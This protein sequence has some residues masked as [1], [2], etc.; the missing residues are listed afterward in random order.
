MLARRQLLLAPATLAACPALAQPASG[1]VIGPDSVPELGGVTLTRLVGG[2]ANPWALAVLPDGDMLVTERPGRL[3]RISRGR[4]DP[5]PVEGVPAVAAFGQGGLLDIALAPDFARDRTL[6]LSFAEGNSAANRT[7]VLRARL[8]GARLADLAVI[9]RAVPD[10]PGGA[11]FGSR[12]LFLPDGTLLVSVGDGGNPNI[13]IDGMPPREQ[14]QRPASALGKLH[15]LNPD[16]SIPADNPFRAAE[17][18]LA[19]LYS[20]GHRNIQGLAWDATR[21]A[22]WASEHGSSGG[23]EL[24]VILRG[25]NFGW[26]RATHSVEYGS[27]APISP[28]RSLPGMEDPKLV[29]LRGIAPSGLAVHSGRGAAAFRGDVFAGGLQSADV[30]RIQAGADGRITGQQ[31]IPVGVRVRDVREGPDGAL[32][33]LTDSQDGT[34]FRVALA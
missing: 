30:R 33:V 34:L 23:D 5:A 31:R 2:L 27:G 16:G 22:V 32:L 3:R 19:S 7:A 18:A 6:F 28:D 1:P 20:I 8:D 11:H 25:R 4:L 26:P 17:G 10:K 9:F 12:L 14:A 13:R 24:N 29:W 15:R 21:G